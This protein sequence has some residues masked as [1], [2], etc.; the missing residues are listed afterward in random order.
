MIYLGM[1]SNVSDEIIS[2]KLVE[3]YLPERLKKLWGI[4]KNCHT[5]SFRIVAL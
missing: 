4:V 3:T 5:Q 2:S 1:S